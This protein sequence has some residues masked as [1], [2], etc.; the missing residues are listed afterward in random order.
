MMIASLNQQ[1]AELKRELALRKNV[2]PKWVAN[3][4]MRQSE[5]DHHMATMTA[6]LH[7]VM[8]VKRLR[9]TLM[10]HRGEGVWCRTDCGE[11]LE[12]TAKCGCGAAFAGATVEI[13]MGG[14]ID[15]VFEQSKAAEEGKTDA[16]PGTDG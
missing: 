12:A 11:V 9:E 13:A 5:M 6:A 14:Y 7:T 2:Y 1:I 16:N 15:H 4:R 3:A 10:Q 8:A